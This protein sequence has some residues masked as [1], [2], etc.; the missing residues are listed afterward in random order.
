MK[1]F[2]LFLTLI[3]IACLSVIFYSRKLTS[4]RQNSFEALTNKPQLDIKENKLLYSDVSQNVSAA[5]TQDQANI[6]APYISAVT[7]AAVQSG[8]LTCTS[9]INQVMAYLT[10]NTESGA[11]LFV[12]P[13]QPGQ[14]IFSSSLELLI[15]DRSSIYSSA[16]FMPN[17][18]GGCDA[19]YDTVEF[20]D[21]SCMDVEQELLK[22]SIKTGALKEHIS[23]YDAGKV[24]FFT[25]NAGQGCILIQKEII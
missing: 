10:G 1:N 9:R 25:I 7:T 4:S 8:V 13:Q 17:A 14:H 18:F 20:I 12:S 22:K 11:Y 3:I 6:R 5:N 15:K 24:K 23:I 2:K 19:V 21:K 16:S